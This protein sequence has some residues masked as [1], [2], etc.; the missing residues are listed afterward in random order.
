MVEKKGSLEISGGYLTVIIIAIVL[1][2]AAYLVY[3]RSFYG[4]A[5]ATCD[6]TTNILSDIFKAMGRESGRVC[7]VGAR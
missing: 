4:T 7:S 3:M 1:L 6:G 2:V 5:G